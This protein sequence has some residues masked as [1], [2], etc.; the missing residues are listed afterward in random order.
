MT[1]ADIFALMPQMGMTPLRPRPSDTPTNHPG[2]WDQ[3]P[4]RTMQRPQ[5]MTGNTMNSIYGGMV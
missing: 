2:W 5:Q 1:L 3:R 4:G